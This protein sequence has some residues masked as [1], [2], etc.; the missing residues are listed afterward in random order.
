MLKLNQK[1]LISILLAGF[2]IVSGEY[3]NYLM[4]NYSKCDNDAKDDTLDTSASKIVNNEL[5]NVNMFDKFLE[6]HLLSS[7]D[8]YSYNDYYLSDNDEVKMNILSENDIKT[9]ALI[10]NLDSEGRYLVSDTL[11]KILDDKGNFITY[12]KFDKDSVVVDLKP[13]KYFISQVAN[14]MSYLPNTEETE[15][16]VSEGKL[17]EVKILNKKSKSGVIIYN[18]DA[19]TGEN[20]SLLNATI[21]DSN[22]SLFHFITNS[23]PYRVVL[24]PG[25]Y[26][27]LVSDNSGF[28]GE[29]EVSYI[30]NVD[31]SFSKIT[32][33]HSKQNVKTK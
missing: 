28:Y 31:Y 25:L 22:N 7:D 33:E 2:T 5:C 16:D 3:C 32:I 10:K 18:V 6:K 13:G 27:L 29:D 21:I 11:L 19:D 26:T 14:N 4:K 17:T 23:D 1:K 15:F 20:I 30:F 24:A 9:G 12:L 8:L